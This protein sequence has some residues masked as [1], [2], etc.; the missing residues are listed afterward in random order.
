MSNVFA[1][2][3]PDVEKEIVAT[4]TEAVSTFTEGLLFAFR[5][6]AIMCPAEKLNRQPD[7]SLLKAGQK[8]NFQE[9]LA[10][11]SFSTED[12]LPLMRIHAPPPASHSS[13]NRKARR[14]T[15]FV[16]RMQDG[17]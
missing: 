15:S 4:F 12:V 5:Y 16:G 13:C 6:A 3:C 10:A 8:E 2:S 9:G 1:V 11:R 7:C 17:S 14:E